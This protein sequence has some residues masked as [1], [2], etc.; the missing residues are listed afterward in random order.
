MKTTITYLEFDTGQ[1]LLE[2]LWRSRLFT[3]NIEVEVW[4]EKV[5]HVQSISYDSEQGIIEEISC[6][7]YKYYQQWQTRIFLHINRT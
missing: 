2:F 6:F 4:N 3:E 7:I 5:K 1:D